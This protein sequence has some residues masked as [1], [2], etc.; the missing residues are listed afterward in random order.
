[1]LIQVAFLFLILLSGG[2]LLCLAALTDPN[3]LPNPQR[4]MLFPLGLAMFFIPI[5]AFLA[6]YALGSIGEIL[7]AFFGSE[8]LSG[9]GVLAGGTVGACSGAAIG[10]LMSSRRMHR[11][12]NK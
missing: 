9:L 1:M 8:I 5:G 12:Q 11:F 2:A 4:Q 3:H 6:G 10:Y 7:D